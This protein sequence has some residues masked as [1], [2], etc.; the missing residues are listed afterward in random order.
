MGIP[1]ERVRSAR[2]TFGYWRRSRPFTAGVLLLSAG[3]VIMIPPYA[4]FRVGDLLVSITTIG[5]VSALLIGTLLAVCGL[6]LW[7]RPQFRLAAGVTAAILSLVALVVTNLGGFLVGTLSG[8]TGAA[9]AVAWTDRPKPPRRSVL[10]TGVVLLFVL[11]QVIGAGAPGAR[12]LPAA[13]SWKVSAST[14]RLDGVVYHGIERVVV[15]G[16]LAETMRFTAR[17]VEAADPVQLAD[18]DNGRRLEIAT[19]PRAGT[20][21]GGSV[22]LFALRVTGIVSVLGLIGIPVDFTPD[23]PPP[24]VPPSVVLTDV[25]AVG[26]LASAATVTVP[27]GK[28]VLR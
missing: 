11:G 21:V 8:L 5:G 18:L 7:L 26:A 19:A 1:W 20:A 9:L 6:S 4:T 25:T 3:G 15:D 2:R 23:H 13:R 10:R 16:R 22:E 27:D 28:L 17:R 24:L 12:D 14:V